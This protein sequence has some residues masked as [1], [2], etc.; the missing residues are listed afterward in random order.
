MCAE[1]LLRPSQSSV[2]LVYECRSLRREPCSLQPPV[3]IYSVPYPT[4][5]PC[6]G[7]VRALHNW[8]QLRISGGTCGLFSSEKAT[9]SVHPSCVS[10]ALWRCIKIPAARHLIHRLIDPSDV[11][12]SDRANR[13]IAS[14][15]GLG[16]HQ[17]GLN[18]SESYALH[19]MN[20][21]EFK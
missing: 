8:H 9:D 17:E 2:A 1:G 10:G 21:N 6:R 5:P 12:A 4:W 19:A 20:S 18:A 14:E 16:T 11:Q 3:L 15:T 7:G 13:F